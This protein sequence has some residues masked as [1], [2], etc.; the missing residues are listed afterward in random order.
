MAA[1]GPRNPEIRGMGKACYQRVLLLPSPSLHTPRSLLFVRVFMSRAGLAGDM[2]MHFHA[3]G[4]W[5]M[6]GERLSCKWRVGVYRGYGV[7]SVHRGERVQ[8]EACRS[9][10][11]KH[12]CMHRVS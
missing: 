3:S 8:V 6:W 9:C 2:D 10:K 5:C 7:L 12:K 11:W 1:R 4:L